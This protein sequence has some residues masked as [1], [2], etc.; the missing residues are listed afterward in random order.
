[1]RYALLGLRTLK[2]LVRRRPDAVLVQNPSLVLSLLVLLLRPVLRYRVIV[3]AHNEA[4]QPFLNRSRFILSATHWVLRNAD[5]TIVTNEPLGRIVS[6]VGGRPFVLPDR[7]PTPPVAPPDTAAVTRQLTLA[8]I[9]TFAGDEPYREVL[10]AVRGLD[11]TL[12]VTGNHRKLAASILDSVPDNVHFTGFLS[13]HDYWALLYRVD[14]IID[15]TTMDNC[16]VCGAYEAVAIARPLILSDNDASI[17]LFGGCAL[18]TDNSID[19]IRARIVELKEALPGLQ[20]GVVLRRASLQAEWE[21]S[22]AQ[23]RLVL[24]PAGATPL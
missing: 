2:L 23:L 11:V 10:E 7:I 5:L 19:D 17:A 8:L 15:L 13:E 16:L 21:R 6:S 12:Y 22:A 1:M 24:D 3:D 9:A 4:V 20:S 18:F 14:A